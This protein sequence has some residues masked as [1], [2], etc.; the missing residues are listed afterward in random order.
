MGD[1]MRKFLFCWMFGVSAWGWCAGA[2]GVVIPLTLQGR[3][4]WAQAEY[5]QG[6]NHLA[7]GMYREA[8]SDFG[9]AAGL[10]EGGLRV[11]AQ[12]EASIG[13]LREQAEAFR[14]ALEGFEGDWTGAVAKADSIR[15][16]LLGVIGGLGADPDASVYHEFGSKL[17]DLLQRLD[18]A[19]REAVEGNRM[20]ANIYL[21]LVREQ[22]DG[23]IAEFGAVQS[24]A[25]DFRGLAADIARR[26]EELAE[27]MWEERE[28]GRDF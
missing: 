28:T 12:R 16:P 25:G 20:E 22:L 1:V 18:M 8:Q 4:E 13:V 6:T 27:A 11:L 26:R 23:E 19:E 17:D 9:R 2:A 7:R 15:E 10:V 24:L 3:L 21:L 14:R 5:A